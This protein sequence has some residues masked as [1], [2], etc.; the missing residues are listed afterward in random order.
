M[1]ECPKCGNLEFVA[2]GKTEGIFTVLMS[3]EK[4][5]YYCELRKV[6][7]LDEDRLMIKNI[8]CPECGWISRLRTQESPESS[9]V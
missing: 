7:H 4:N 9:E 2:E 3:S 8:R 5:G 6:D 1:L